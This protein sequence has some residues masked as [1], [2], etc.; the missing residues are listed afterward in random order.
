MKKGYILFVVCLLFFGMAY[1]D[2][3]GSIRGTV[4]AAGTNEPLMG[5]NIMVEDTRMGTFTDQTGY[6]NII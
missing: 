1:G 2:I 6:Y 5:V 4:V 3:V